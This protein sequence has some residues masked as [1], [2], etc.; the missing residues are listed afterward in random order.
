[1]AALILDIDVTL[2]D[3]DQEVIQNMVSE[4]KNMGAELYVNTS[5]VIHNPFDPCISNITTKTLNIP[6]N[7]HYCRNQFLSPPSKLKNMNEILSDLNSQNLHISRKCMIL[8]DD[9]EDN[10]ESVKMGGYSTIQTPYGIQQKHADEI[11]EKIKY[12]LKQ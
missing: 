6:E 11:L 5:R 4:A 9:R 12:C 8:V 1:M 2:T 7:R 3:G 10:C